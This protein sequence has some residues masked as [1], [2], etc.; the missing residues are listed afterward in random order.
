MLRGRERRRK[1]RREAESEEN[2]DRETHK[3][4][5]VLETPK[6]LNPAQ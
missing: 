5:Q 2:E 1:Y 6:D 3:P 4:C